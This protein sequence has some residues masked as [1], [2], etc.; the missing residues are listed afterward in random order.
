MDPR[1]SGY[2]FKEQQFQPLSAR[3]EEHVLYVEQ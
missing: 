1:A 3:Q 2:L